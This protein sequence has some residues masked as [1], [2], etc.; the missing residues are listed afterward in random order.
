[1]RFSRGKNVDSREDGWVFSRGGARWHGEPL[2][3]RPSPPLFP[4]VTLSN[5]STSRMLTLLPSATT[6]Y[7]VKILA[8][9]LSLCA[10]LNSMRNRKW[11]YRKAVLLP[12]KAPWN[13]LLLH[14]DHSSFLLMTGLTC[15]AFDM[16]H[17]I[18]K[19][20]GHPSLPKRKGRKW[21][22]TS[23][24]QLG[25]FLFYIGSTMN[26]KYLCL[27]F[28]VTPN[29]C[30]RMLKNMLKLVVTW[31][32]YH[33]LARIKFPTLEKMELFA[34]MVNNREPSIDD[35]IGVMDGV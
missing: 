27:I 16:L 31:L 26:Y 8:L 4:Y 17:K 21:S 24:G 28:G 13:Y 5:K 30:S 2:S 1:M 15:K 34:S 12:S 22:M 14:G 29:A 6:K 3:T 35:V 19:P 9:V 32:W 11:L 10:Y 7:R 18:L 23:E 33:P 25:L 20:P